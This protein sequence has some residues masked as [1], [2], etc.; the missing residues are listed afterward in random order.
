MEYQ[1]RIKPSVKKELARLPKQDRQRIIA[2][3]YGLSRNP[4]IGK[5]LRGE[6][7]DYY[8]LRVWPYRI[9]YQLYKKELLIIVIKVGYRQGVY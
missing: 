4:F 6:L 3:F 7:R 2:A 9:I 8:S 5:K 1:L